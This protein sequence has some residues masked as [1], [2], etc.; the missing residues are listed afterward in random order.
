MMA[1]RR[2]AS[3][4]IHTFNLES[5]KAQTVCNGGNRIITN[6]DNFPILKGMALYLLRL[7]KDGIREPHWHPNASELGYCINGKALMTVFS[8]EAGHDTFTIDPG[9]I[10]F[11]PHGYMHHIENIGM[12]DTNFVLAFDHEKPEDLGISGSVGSVP[13][14]ILDATFGVKSKFFSQ[15]K[16]ES[17]EDILIGARSFSL[18]SSASGAEYYQ[19]I[20][21]RH[22][23][24]LEGIP[25]QIQTTGGTVALGNV[26]SFPILRG[27]ACYSLYLRPGGIR[28]PHWHPNAAELDYV[29]QGK[30]KMTILS[31]GGNVDTF[32]VGGGEIVFIPPAYFHYIENIDVEND[33]H[34]VV[35]FGHERPE[36]IGISG[37][38][39]AYSNE[40]L[41]AAFGTDPKIF[42]S[43]ARLQ[44]DVFVV[45]G[46][47]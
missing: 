44:E 22:K 11:V 13:A 8:P 4:S 10:A 7:H 42:D 15:F 9:E 20:P 46:G 19:R 25:P 30:A 2:M 34:F 35:F 14:K 37:A 3:S 43:L 28:E 12:E 36:D 29:I 21:N 24:N 41:S 45:A 31:P 5:T 40:V 17:P 33:T 18:S 16:K 39:S 1:K 47:A 26:N 38:L 32:E 23:F 6:S 27:L